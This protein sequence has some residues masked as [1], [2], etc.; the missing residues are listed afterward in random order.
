MFS[1]KIKV[2][3]MMI[4]IIFL[5]T[6]VTPAQVALKDAFQNHFLIGAALNRAQFYEVDKRGAEIV[7]THFNTISPENVLKWES[8]H[9]VKGGFDFTDAD[10]FVAFGEKNE[11]FIVGHTLVWHNQTPKWVFEDDRGGRVTRDEL[12]K[13]LREHIQTVVGR[14]KGRIKGWDV[15]NEALNEDGTLRPT[16]W[17]KIIGEDYIARAFEYAHQ[18]DPEA[19]LYYND[20]SLENEPKRKGA[21]K[22]IKKLLAQKIPVKAIGLQGHNN[23]KFPTL[24]QQEATI[25]DFAELGVK[26]M[27]TELDI[28]VLPR[29]GEFRGA[30]LNQNFQLQE[31]L[32]P[33]AKS[34]PDSLQQALAKRYADLFGI[35]LKHKKDITRVTFWGVTDGDTWLNNFPIRGRTNYPLLFDREGRIKPAFEAVIQ[36]ARQSSMKR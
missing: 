15:V 25:T 27:I 5:M 14:Y 24:E 30:D 36:S 10:R 8:V 23:M 9:P 11:M 22:L 32:N 21:I 7:K 6:T 29:A 13:R 1:A 3:S 19:E 12:L 2:F 17:L 18:A 26:V 16:R 33:Y 28:D 34:L 35:F 20:Y 4:L 31:K